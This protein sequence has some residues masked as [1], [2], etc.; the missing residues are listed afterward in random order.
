MITLL[1][2]TMGGGT[3]FSMMKSEHIFW[4]IALIAGLYLLIGTGVSSFSPVNAQFANGYN[5]APAAPAGGH[6]MPDGTWM[7]GDMG[8][9]GCQMGAGGGGCGCG[10]GR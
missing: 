2:S 3:I 1:T 9:G 6:Y 8:G 5:A 7:A 10:G 4:G